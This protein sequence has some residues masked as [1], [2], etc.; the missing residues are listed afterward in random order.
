MYSKLHMSLKKWF[1]ILLCIKKK[2][3]KP[4]KNGQMMIDDVMK[5]KNDLSKKIEE[6]SFLN[7]KF[8]KTI[9]F[10]FFKKKDCFIFS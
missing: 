1:V 4:I 9:P 7:F 10:F 8:F 3:F 5:K 2:N 6:I